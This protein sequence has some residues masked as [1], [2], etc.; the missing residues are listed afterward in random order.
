MHPISF[1]VG[2]VMW[3]CSGQWHVRGSVDRTASTS[4]HFL[5]AWRSGTW[6]DHSGNAEQRNGCHLLGT[7][8][9]KDRIR[10]TAGDRWAIT[11][12]LSYLFINFTYLKEKLSCLRQIFCLICSWT[13]TWVNTHFIRLRQLT[14]FL[15]F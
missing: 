15:A 2:V 10:W 13:Q 8:E 6:Q 5:S 3:L 1:A 9:P 14:S 12:P 7:N 11:A 4:P